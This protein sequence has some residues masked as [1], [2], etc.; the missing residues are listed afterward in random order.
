MFELSFGEILLFTVIALVVLGPE[1]LP[2]VARFIGT[3]VGRVQRF[4]SNVKEEFSTQLNDA[5]LLQM[6]E[7]LQAAA[8]AMRLEMQTNLNSVEQEVQSLQQ[9][10]QGHETPAWQR[11]PEMRT[12]ADFSSGALQ[13]RAQLRLS[14]RRG[15]VRQQS[16]Q[17]R[18]RHHPKPQPVPRLRARHTVRSS[19]HS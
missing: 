3:W 10:L 9:Q 2:G 14:M 13:E 8:E 1:R 5:Q 18:R 6:R 7:G 17:Q 11:L 16:L 12:P 15:S 4:V 19:P